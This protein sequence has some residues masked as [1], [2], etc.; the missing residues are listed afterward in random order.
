MLLATRR[1]IVKKTEL[2]AFRNPRPSGIIALGV[3]DGDQLIDVALTSGEDE[4]L[5]RDRDGM[6]IHFSEK[7]VRPM[8]RTAYG[9][10]GIELREGDAVVACRW[11]GRGAPSSPSRATATASARPRRVPRADPG[12]Q[13]HHQH[14]DDRPERERRR[15]RLGARR[16]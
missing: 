14:Q 8:G 1:G 12:R 16:G 4:L 5:H 9:V 15:H 13:G 10:K 3:E 6:A 7:D 2:A 11:Y